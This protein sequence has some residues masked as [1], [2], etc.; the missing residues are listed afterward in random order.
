MLGQSYPGALT[1]ATENARGTGHSPSCGDDIAG[2]HIDLRQV[3][4]YSASDIGPALQTAL[5]S[6]LD[7]GSGGGAIFIPPVTQTLTTPVVATI[8][9]GQ[10]VRLY[11]V[12]GESAVF[13]NVGDGATGITITHAISGGFCS[14]LRFDDFALLGDGRSFTCQRGIYVDSAFQSRVAISNV[15]VIGL[16]ARVAHVEVEDGICVVDGY[17]VAGSALDPASAS[18]SLS[19][20]RVYDASVKNSMHAQRTVFNGVNYA[21]ASVLSLVNWQAPQLNFSPNASYG[22]FAAENLVTEDQ[23]S[24]GVLINNSAVFRGGAVDIRNCRFTLS[25]VPG[26]CGLFVR[27]CDSLNVDNVF[28]NNPSGR[29]GQNLVEMRNVGESTVTHCRAVSSKLF[30]ADAQCGTVSVMESFLVPGPGMSALPSSGVDPANACDSVFVTQK[31]IRSRLVGASSEIA[32]NTLVKPD[33][34]GAAYVQ[35][36][37]GDDGALA[38][39]L[40]QDA[41]YPSPGAYVFRAIERRGQVAI[42]AT[43]GTEISAGDKLYASALVGG[44]GTV[45]SVES[46]RQIGVA[47]TSAAARQVKIMFI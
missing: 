44:G 19:L 43:D 46:G 11:G 10:E 15:R 47:L 40:L 38:A 5:N 45:S 18:G 41:G 20:F 23:V 9:G 30:F 4:G 42:A 7:A 37:E 27:N 3:A 6:L 13:V 21:G 31:G 29:I 2:S 8:P 34:Q 14:S 17:S 12:P 35:L 25:G 36:S 32:A 24:Y 1:S 26:A 16:L 33:T 22:H 39:A 28:Q